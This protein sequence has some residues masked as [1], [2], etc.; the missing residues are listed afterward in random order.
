MILSAKE[1]LKILDENAVKY[2]IES[3][4]FEILGSD[5]KANTFRKFV[6]RRK[7]SDELLE[8]LRERQICDGEFHLELSNAE[9]I[10]QPRTVEGK[11]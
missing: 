4:K 8:L 11:L 1:V 9:L 5:D 2:G 10:R 7:F 3:G 6:E